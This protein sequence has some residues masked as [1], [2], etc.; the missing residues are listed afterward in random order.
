MSKADIL[1][2]KLFNYAT[3]TAQPNPIGESEN[4]RGKKESLG[5]SLSSTL[6]TLLLVLF[7][8]VLA[9]VTLGH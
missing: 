7:H 9:T 2:R 6:L 3:G 4:S 5:A 1:G 8:R